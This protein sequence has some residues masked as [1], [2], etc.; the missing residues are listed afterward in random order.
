MYLAANNTQA[1]AAEANCT[2]VLLVWVLLNEMDAL[3]SGIA[4][5]PSQK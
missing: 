1:E 2:S 3:L 5:S 4:T